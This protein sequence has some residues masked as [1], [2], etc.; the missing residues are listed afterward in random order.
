MSFASPLWLLAL[1]VVPAA[2]AARRSRRRRRQRYVI[3]HPATA[4]VARA[5]AAAPRWPRHVPAALLLAALASLVVALARPRVTHRVPTDKASL[6]LVSDHSGSMA[7]DDVRPT[8][9]AAAI[10]SANSFIDT[11]P[12]SVRVGAIGFSNAPDGV[13]G[14]TLDHG[15]ARRVIDDQQAVGGTDTGAALQLALALLDGAAAHHP[16]S[17][18]V[19]LSDGAANAGPNPL[20]VSQLAGREHIPIYTVALGTAAGVVTAP[21]SFG[22]AVS[23]PPDPRLMAQIAELSG[24]RAFNAR[25]ADELGTIYRRLGTELS[26]IPRPR[27]VTIAFVIAGAALLLAAAAAAVRLGGRLP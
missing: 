17:A 8:R 18:I 24:A 1:L 16:P 10:S 20:G 13:Q 15:A 4:V 11:L 7:A 12:A 6:M 5:I 3:R 22:P 14:P 23:V 19:L 9:L 21:G 26:T 27:D 2:V 25:S